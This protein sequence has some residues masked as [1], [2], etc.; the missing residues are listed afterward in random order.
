[1]QAVVVYAVEDG[2]EDESCGARD[3]GYDADAAVDFLVDGGVGGEFAR[4]SE[5]PLE[6][7]GDIEGDHGYGGHGDEEG[8]EALCADI[9]VP[10]LATLFSSSKKTVRGK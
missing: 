8:L 4:V 5:P 9:W 1:M 7:E 10:W 2:E 3:G 6:D